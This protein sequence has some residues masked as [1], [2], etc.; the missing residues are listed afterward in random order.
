MVNGIC[1]PDMVWVSLQDKYRTVH[2]RL[3]LVVAESI[4]T[5]DR[6]MELPLWLVDIFKASI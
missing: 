1:T 3:P 5:V 2:P 6:H 4:L